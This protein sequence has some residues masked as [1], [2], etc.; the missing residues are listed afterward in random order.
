[1]NFSK[2]VILVIA[3]SLSVIG[4]I[5]SVR[6]IV[7]HNQGNSIH[8]VVIAPNSNTG[9]S[10]IGLPS[11]ETT[12]TTTTRIPVVPRDEV[13]ARAYIV[14]DLKTGTIYIEKYA[15]TPLPVASMS[16][17]ITAIVATDTLTP[18]TTV[19]ITELNMNVA[20]DTS[21]ISAGE[22]Y[23]MHELLYPLLL[24]SS[25]VAAEA[26]A[27]TSDRNAFFELMKSYAWEVGASTAFFADPSGLSPQNVASGHDLFSLA[28]YL[29]TFRQDILELTRTATSSIATTTDH[30]AHEFVSTHP[31]VTDPRFLGGKTGRTVEA[32]ET[33]MTLMHIKNHDIVCVVLGSRYGERAHDTAI[34]LQRTEKLIE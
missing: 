19:A 15:T 20:S 25:N 27:S 5:A 34:L 1:M 8:E 33:M 21:R 23:T 10:A 12:S 7:T 3:I 4:I 9:E 18:T 11:L 24:S 29:Y 26:I 31:F 16:K 6:Y 13:T 2:R 32:G 30:G 14:G 28:Q 22:T 17:L